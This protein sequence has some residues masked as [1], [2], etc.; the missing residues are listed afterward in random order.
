MLEY[1]CGMISAGVPVFFCFGIIRRSK[2]SFL[3]STVPY[4]YH[5]IRRC[6]VFSC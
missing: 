4:Q 3:A 2:S 5:D 1:E 6:F